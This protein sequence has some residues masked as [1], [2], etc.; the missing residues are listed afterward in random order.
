MALRNAAAR[1]SAAICSR[2]AESSPLP[3][4]CSWVSCVC[5]DAGSGCL[6]ALMAPSSWAQWTSKRTP[7]GLNVAPA[8]IAHA[9][10]DRAPS[11][12]LG[13]YVEAG[14]RGAGAGERPAEPLA[15][16][17]DPRTVSRNARLAGAHVD[18]VVLLVRVAL[19]VVEPR[20]PAPPGRPGRSRR[21]TSRE[22]ER[23]A[24]IRF[25]WPGRLAR[26]GP[27]LMVV[28]GEVD[29]VLDARRRARRSSTGLRSSPERS[30]C[31][32]SGAAPVASTGVRSRPA[33]ALLLR[34]A[35]RG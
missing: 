4:G 25:G 28:V 22:S 20:T 10:P 27:R 24:R 1:R 3:S 12:R 35:A 21:R 15:Q 11:C 8:C 26:R 34:V 14:M 6:E 16:S 31:S 17:L 32:R 9:R 33:Q 23:T 7:A 13:S 30:S 18:Q 2:W 29:V 5:S 19:E